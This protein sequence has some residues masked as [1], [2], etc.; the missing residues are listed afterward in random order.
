MS[1]RTRKR[2]PRDAAFV[3]LDEI[4]KGAKSRKLRQLIRWRAEWLERA[5]PNQLAPPGEWDDWLVLAGRGFG[6]TR[7]GAEETGFN[8]CA[9]ASTRWAAVA[10]TQNDCR[11]VMFEGESGLLNVIPSIFVKKYRADVLELELYNNSVIY[12]KSAEKP[13]R[14]RGPQYH[15][16][17]C[18]E[19]ASWQRLQDTWDNLKFGLRLGAHPR[20]IITTTPRPIPFLKDLLKRSQGDGPRVVT[21]T[22]STF[23]NAANLAPSALRAFREVY[24]GT[25]KGRQE[26]YAEI[27]DTNE[28]ALWKPSQLELCEVDDH[29][30]LVRIVIAVD[31]AVTTEDD[32]DE[33]GIVVAGLGEDGL[34]YVLQDLSGHYSPLE[35]AR[36]VVMA[37]NRWQADKVVAETNQGGD[38]VVANIHVVDANIPVEKVHAKRGKYLRAEPI[39][40]QYEKAK[41]RHVGR[42][43]KL[44]SQML[45]YTGSTDKKSPDRLDALVYAIGEILQG[46]VGHAFW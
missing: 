40:A 39:A 14:L 44:E 5:R 38:L 18:D 34:A 43:T 21:S 17:W 37:Y 46:S 4:L 6:K 19:V 32:S 42:F 41:V 15:G 23:E 16:A 8:A 24:E 31:P 9:Y 22:G 20:T 35:W 29:P 27:L 7:M 26:L 13:D 10:P 11:T 3:E 45:N 36:V 1:D 25:R 2:V 28:N 30:A 33:T 12:G